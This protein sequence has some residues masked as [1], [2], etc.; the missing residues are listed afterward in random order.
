MTGTELGLRTQAQNFGQAEAAS[1]LRE[2]VNQV[3]SQQGWSQ[4]QAEATFREQMAQQASQQGW[5]QA[6]AGPAESVYA[7]LASAAVEPGPATAATTQTV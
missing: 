5:N 1:R 7:G 3:A 2:Q 6:L 4:A